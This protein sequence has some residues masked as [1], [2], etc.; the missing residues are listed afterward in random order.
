MI[1]YRT[2][3]NYYVQN[4]VRILSIELELKIFGIWTFYDA[5]SQVHP[6]ITSNSSQLKPLHSKILVI[7]ALLMQYLGGSVSL[8]YQ[9][10]F[11]GSLQISLGGHGVDSM[12]VSSNIIA[13]DVLRIRNSALSVL[14]LPNPL[15]WH[16][17][18]ELQFYGHGR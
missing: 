3:S 16:V 6:C 10:L 9:T 18:G 1:F 4:K 12:L 11:Q 17:T 15:I 7:L 8:A 5:F 13:F 2:K 14:I